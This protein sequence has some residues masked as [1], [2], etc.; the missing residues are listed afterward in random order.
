MDVTIVIPTYNGAHKIPNLLDSLESQTFT[1]FQI[2]IVIDGSTDNTIEVINRYKNHFKQLDY[3]VQENGGRAKVRNTGARFASG[4]LLIFLDD[5]LILSKDCLQIHYDHH[6]HR[7]QSIL[8]GSAIEELNDTSKESNK[9]KQFLSYKWIKKLEG[10]ES[11]ALTAN[12]IFVTA[13]N[14][15]IR[16]SDFLNLDGFDERLKDAEDFD[17]AVRAF[18]AGLHLYFNFKAYAVHNESVS[19]VT[20]IKRLRQ[21]NIAQKHLISLK[22]WLVEQGF[23]KNA[24]QKPKGLKSKIFKI[25]ASS[26][27]IRSADQDLFSF[28]PERLRFK[29]Y[30]LIVTSNSIFY[31]DKVSL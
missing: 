4:E 30:D 25:F 11:E 29:L 7:K 21:Y 28:L 19:F 6:I 9:F 1:D 2:M 14:F 17:F 5:D 10:H 8:T 22:P 27:W 23:T 3:I 18:K 31:P 24:N 13:A 12:N 26:F 16:K 15:S 20:F